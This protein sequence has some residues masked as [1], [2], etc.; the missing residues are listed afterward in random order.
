MSNL[1]FLMEFKEEVAQLQAFKKQTLQDLIGVCS[2]YSNSWKD[3]GRIA[4]EIKEI[5]DRQQHRRSNGFDP[6]K[7][8]HNLRYSPGMDERERLQA[9]MVFETQKLDYEQDEEIKRA[10]E[11]QFT[12]ARQRAGNSLVYIDELH[13]VIQKVSKVVHEIYNPE[14]IEFPDD[15]IVGDKFRNLKRIRNY[16]PDD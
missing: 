13:R 7:Q 2:R 10:L 1:F 3:H 12:A 6:N 16:T 15:E 8:V 4:S 14:D 11:A 5:T 9:K